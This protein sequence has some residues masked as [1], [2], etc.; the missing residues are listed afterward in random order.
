MNNQNVLDVAFYFAR[1]LDDK[2]GINTV[3]LD[4]QKISF[5]ADYFIIT[6]AQSTTHLK[7]LSN[8]IIKKMKESNYINRNLTYEGNPHTGWILL[9]FGDIVIHLFTKDR[10]EYYNLEY[11]WHEAKKIP[12]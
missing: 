5:I 6:T 2:K 8:T 7:T 9:D 1:L 4:I 10:R 3:L 12:F 11:I